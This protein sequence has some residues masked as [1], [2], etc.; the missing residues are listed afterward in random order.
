MPPRK[1]KL[2]GGSAT[3]GTGD[4]KPQFLTAATPVP[5]GASDYTLIAIS[6]PRIILGEEDRA[7]IM[8]ILRI[9]Y[10]L[11]LANLNDTTALQWGFLTTRLSRAQDEGSSFTTLREDTQQPGTIGLMGINHTLTTSGATTT[12]FPLSFD[13]TDQNGNGILIATDRI[14]FIAGGNGEATPS[15][16]AVKILYRMVNVGITEYVGIVQSQQ[17]P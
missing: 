5:A 3:G 2:S 11:G 6:I 1:R 15:D 4:L 9:D 14:F 16:A 17:G 7:T 8:E 13:T 12:Y 10:Y